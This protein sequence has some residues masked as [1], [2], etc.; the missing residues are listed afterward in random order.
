MNH[1]VAVTFPGLENGF[2]PTL[3][4]TLSYTKHNTIS[5]SEK[6]YNITDNSG[7][8]LKLKNNGGSG[9]NSS[10]EQFDPLKSLEKEEYD[11]RRAKENPVPSQI[12]KQ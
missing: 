2:F 12:I 9:N 11:I 6:P 8:G 7:G 3:K 10:I 4:K 5:S 1:H